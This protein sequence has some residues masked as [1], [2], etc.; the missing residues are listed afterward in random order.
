[1]YFIHEG[2]NSRHTI[3]HLTDALR[4]VFKIFS[5]LFFGVV[6]RDIIHAEKN[7][8][9]V[10]SAYC[11]PVGDFA[12]ENQFDLFGIQVLYFIGF[13][14]RHDGTFFCR[15]LTEQSASFAEQKNHNENNDDT[16]NGTADIKQYGDEP[17]K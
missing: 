11:F 3:H 8:A 4:K 16:R 2:N 7:N 6:V 5:D 12:I 13:V 1:M 15:F 17:V 14:H 9:V 10:L